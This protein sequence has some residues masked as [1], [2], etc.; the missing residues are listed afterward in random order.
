MLRNPWRVFNKTSVIVNRFQ[1]FQKAENW[2]EIG[3]ILFTELRWPFRWQGAIFQDQ[4]SFLPLTRSGEA[5]APT[6][7]TFDSGNGLADRKRPEEKKAVKRLTTKKCGSP[8]RGTYHRR[9]QAPSSGLPPFYLQSLKISSNAIS[10]AV[11]RLFSIM[12]K[13]C[14][15]KVDCFF[16]F[17]LSLS[18]WL[19]WF[20]PHLWFWFDWLPGFRCIGLSFFCG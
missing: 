2:G 7:S 5:C 8:L 9:Y 3:R 11:F 12:L 14:A 16:F 6:K 4:K 10:T 20:L 18:Y 19:I 15:S 17:F 13:I 1:P